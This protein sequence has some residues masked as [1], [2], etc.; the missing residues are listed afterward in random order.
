MPLEGTANGSSSDF[1]VVSDSS[2][3]YSTYGLQVF[4]P[5]AITRDKGTYHAV[6][7]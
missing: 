7:L 5:V 4:S 6:M 1:D 3:I 2:G